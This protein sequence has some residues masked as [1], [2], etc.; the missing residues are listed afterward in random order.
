MNKFEL[1]K[2]TLSKAAGRS[3][4]ILQKYSPEI[5]TTVGVV[6]IVVSTVMACKATTKGRRVLKRQKGNLDKCHEVR[7]IFEWEK[8]LY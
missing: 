7:K 1:V 2:I 8:I 6:G 3:G 4:L 5:L